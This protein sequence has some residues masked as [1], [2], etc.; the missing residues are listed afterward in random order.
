MN[1]EESLGGSVNSKECGSRK[2]RFL[3]SRGSAKAESWMT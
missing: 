3:D 1:L 2:K